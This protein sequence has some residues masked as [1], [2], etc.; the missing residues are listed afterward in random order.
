M[1]LVVIFSLLVT[2]LTL[3][4]GQVA[5]W[6]PNVHFGPTKSEIVGMSV[7]LIPGHPP[8]KE[9][10]F[11]A[12]WPGLWNPHTVQYDLVQSVIASHKRSYMEWFCKAKPG[13]W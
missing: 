4:N 6:G 8:A 9:V 13:Q 5:H 11:V 10:D 1:S 12:I 3:A 7:T 2:F